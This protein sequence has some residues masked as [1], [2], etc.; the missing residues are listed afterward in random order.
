M[1]IK[2]EWRWSPRPLLE[3]RWR[4]SPH[5]SK[6]ILCVHVI[7]RGIEINVLGAYCVFGLSYEIKSAPLTEEEKKL[8]QDITKREGNA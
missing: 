4:K 3:I 2:C 1:A 6:V 5:R 7:K 8:I